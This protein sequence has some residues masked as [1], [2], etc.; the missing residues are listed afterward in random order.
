[1]TKCPIAPDAEKAADFIGVV[2]VI[3]RETLVSVMFALRRE[4]TDCA[5]AILISKEFFILLVS[6]AVFAQ[7][8]L[9][10]VALPPAASGFT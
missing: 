6:E 9:E 7:L 2:V 10:R 5:E 3:N 8:V 1:M 4:L